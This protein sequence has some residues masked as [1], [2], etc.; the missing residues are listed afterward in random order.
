MLFNFIFLYFSETHILQNIWWL[1]PLYVNCEILNVEKTIEQ[2]KQL[3]GG[4]FL[5][6]L[7]KIS[8]KSQENTCARVSFLVKFQVKACVRYSL[9]IHYT[10]DLIT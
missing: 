3:P 9:K 8:K 1:L 2:Q 6:V 10:S 7:L 4:V 5:K